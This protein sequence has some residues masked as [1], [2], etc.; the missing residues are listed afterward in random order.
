MGRTVLPSTIG[1]TGPKWYVDERPTD[2]RL[3]HL[4][5]Q[6]SCPA[7]HGLHLT[8][9]KVPNSQ[10]RSIFRGIEESGRTT[11]VRQE[12]GKKTKQ[13]ESACPFTVSRET[14]IRWL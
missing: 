10:E 8:A 9:N 2:F 7:A 5:H 6:V 13:K 14:S 3:T 12:D 11:E 4:S 1:R